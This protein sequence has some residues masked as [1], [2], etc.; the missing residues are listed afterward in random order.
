MSVVTLQ[1]GQCGNQIGFEVFDTLFSD[2]HCSQIFCSKK[3][4]E[5]YLASCMERFFREE[6]SGGMCGPQST[7][8]AS[9]EPALCSP[10]QPPVSGSALTHLK[11]TSP[12]PLLSRASFLRLT[13][14]L[15]ILEGRMLLQPTAILHLTQTPLHILRTASG[16]LLVTK[17]SC[18]LC[19]CLHFSTWL[20]GISQ[21]NLFCSSVPELSQCLHHVLSFVVLSGKFQSLVMCFFLT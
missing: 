14:S 15:K 1:L 5:A 7:P 19:N 17:R 11:F 16:D 4:N 18:P 6:E 2:S 21:A 10:S 9:W 8:T 3:E 13:S 20:D 12:T